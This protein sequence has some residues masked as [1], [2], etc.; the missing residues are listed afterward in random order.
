MTYKLPPYSIV[1]D[2][3][4]EVDDW[5][6]LACGLASS[7]TYANPEGSRSLARL[8]VFLLWTED[9]NILFA[10]TFLLMFSVVCTRSLKM[11]VQIFGILKCWALSSHLWTKVKF[12]PRTCSSSS[13]FSRYWSLRSG[14]QKKETPR[15][16]SWKPLQLLCGNFTVHWSLALWVCIT[17]QD[18]K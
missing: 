4:D 5:G 9:D 1:I 2:A 16:A 10:T 14:R 11:L 7:I 12:S 3:L 17:K 15:T 18:N 8:Q 6:G 13:V